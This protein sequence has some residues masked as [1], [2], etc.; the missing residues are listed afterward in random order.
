MHQRFDRRRP[1][2]RPSGLRAITQCFELAS[3]KQVR[4]VLQQQFADRQ[5]LRQ[6]LDRLVMTS[7]LAEYPPQPN[8]RLDELGIPIEGALVQI[9][10]SC[11]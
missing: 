7:P 3:Q 4:L 6:L 11:S 2:I 9:R 10:R 5:P 1:F 8:P